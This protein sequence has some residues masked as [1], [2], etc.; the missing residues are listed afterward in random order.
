MPKTIVKY[1]K[2]KSMGR[3]GFIMLGLLKVQVDVR[4]DMLSSLATSKEHPSGPVGT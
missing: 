3:I 2:T 4:E 1:P